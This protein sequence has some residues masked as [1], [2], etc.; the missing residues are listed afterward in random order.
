M[1]IDVFALPV[2][3]SAEIFPMMADAEIDTMAAD[4]KANGLR[5]PIVLD[6]E[7]GSILDGR[8]RREACRR[9]GVKITTW[10][11]VAP[12]TDPLKFVISA[13]LERRHLSEGQRAMVADNIVTTKKGGDHGQAAKRWG[14]SS[15]TNSSIEPLV[16][17]HK[18]N[19]Q[20]SQADAADIMNVSQ[21]SVKR[22]AT[23]RNKGAP[24][25]IAAVESGEISL[26]KAEQIATQVPKDQQPLAVEAAKPTKKNATHV[27]K[28]VAAKKQAR[29]PS[30]EFKVDPMLKEKIE[31]AVNS[32][33][34]M[35]Q[36]SSLL[37]DAV[38]NSAL[39]SSS[40]PPVVIDSFLQRLDVEIKA[41]ETLGRSLK[42]AKAYV[43]AQT[44]GK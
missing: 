44:K 1:N 42:E 11:V 16:H 35:V 3:P 32:G 41:R 28:S 21:T 38:S 20:I 33:K 30:N 7:Q 31:R 8:N 26:A 19:N 23:V 24:E 2:H 4:I 17:E 13:N 39:D 10:D 36:A 15:S 25:T 37:H 12:G 22:A 6:E 40:F 34:D 29:E 27:S 14:S 9:A 5:F 43:L 18:E